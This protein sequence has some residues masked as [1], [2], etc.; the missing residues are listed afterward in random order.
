[1][2][3]EFSPCWTLF[4]IIS[5]FYCL[6]ICPDHFSGGFAYLW[7][8]SPALRSLSAKINYWSRE[9]E[10]RKGSAA[11]APSTFFRAPSQGGPGPPTSAGPS[12]LV[13]AT[14]RASRALIEARCDA[15]PVVTT[16][17]DGTVGQLQTPPLGKM[18]CEASSSTSPARRSLPPAAIAGRRAAIQNAGSGSA[19]PR[20][21]H[22]ERA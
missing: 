15:R 7:H 20:A 4:P 21:A 1:M 6:K 13:P 11:R 3:A 9:K 17:N 16:Q 10:P 14:P 12:S 2:E 18:S 8:I 22:R 19:G 5:V